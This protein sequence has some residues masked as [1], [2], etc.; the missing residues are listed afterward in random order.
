MSE[1]AKK[2]FD[3]SGR[4][5][6]VTGAGRSIGR[7]IALALAERGAAIAVND[8]YR[9]RAEEVAAEIEAAGG[10]AIGLAADVTDLGAVRTMVAQVKGK[11]GPT[12][13]L[14]NNAGIPADGFFPK[15]FADTTPE[16]WDTFVQLNLYGVFHCVHSVIGDMSE[17]GW[18]RI[19]T[20]SSEAWR[21]GVSFGVSLYAA[22]KA[23]A[24]G[25]TR[26]LAAEL[27]SKGVTANCVA[28]GEMENLPF[29]EELAK[30]YPTGRLGKPEDVAAV[31]VYLTSNEAEW[32]TGQTI[33]LNGGLVTF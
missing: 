9:E 8:L 13:I 6:L 30:R 5:A 24:I 29:A 18:G 16:D 23:G 33:P 11:F 28:L 3:L 15:Q 2:S 21:T 10:R 22:G 25:F 19:I 20:I 32:M 12:D 7:G 4:V 14:I 27:A 17:R 26:H 31:V 1:S